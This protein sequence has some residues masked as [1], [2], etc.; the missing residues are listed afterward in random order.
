MDLFVIYPLILPIY[1]S[2]R[3]HGV[4]ARYVQSGSFQLLRLW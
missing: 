2:S 3:V 1:V 4:H